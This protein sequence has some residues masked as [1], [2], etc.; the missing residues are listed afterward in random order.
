[1]IRHRLAGG[2]Q[3]RPNAT[4]HCQSRPRRSQ[5]RGIR[6][7][8]PDHVVAL[9][10]RPAYVSES[11]APTAAARC[12]GLRRRR[13]DLLSAL[14]KTP[15]RR[16]YRRH[17]LP[18]AVHVAGSPLWRMFL[19]KLSCSIRRRKDAGHYGRQAGRDRGRHGNQFALAASIHLAVGG[20]VRL[21]SPQA[22]SAR[23]ELATGAVYV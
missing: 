18:Q 23:A 3:V 5:S 14:R 11:P 17:R 12:P 19:R 8:A 21:R 20:A 2:R 1:M 22:D 10:E 15:L 4:M 7:E 16:A 6:G 13:P 9:T